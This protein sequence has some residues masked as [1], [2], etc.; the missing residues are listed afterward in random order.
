MQTTTL[1][2]DRD[3][4]IN[5]RTPGDYVKNRAAFMF[6]QG[7]LQALSLLAGLFPRIVV[8][9]NQAGVGR[10]LMGIDSVADVHD[11]MIEQVQALGGRIDRAY[12]CPHHSA[13][14]CNCRK[15]APGMAMQ[16]LAD[17]PEINFSRAWM[18]GDSASDM[19]FGTQLGMKTVLLPGKFEDADALA[20]MSVDYRF[21]NLLAFAQYIEAADCFST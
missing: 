16:A 4:V 3:G 17:F 21:E 7:A 2:L 9:T 19:V 1:F 13:M 20:N 6:E 10:G 15:P 8:V 12:F 14:G 5:V 11:Y 18:V